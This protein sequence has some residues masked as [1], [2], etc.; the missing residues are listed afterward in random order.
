ML[1]CY[2]HIL[3]CPAP[4]RATTVLSIRPLADD[5][6]WR[7]GQ[8]DDNFSE[9]KALQLRLPKAR[10]NNQNEVPHLNRLMYQGKISSAIP[11]LEPDHKGGVLYLSQSKGPSTVLD[12]LK[13]KC[14]RSRP[15]TETSCR[16][17]WSSLSCFSL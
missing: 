1:P 2:F 8:L 9:S 13:G 4:R 16:K 6:M 7:Q 15:H 10:K 3:Y 11:Q 12:V 17:S 5:S 14:K